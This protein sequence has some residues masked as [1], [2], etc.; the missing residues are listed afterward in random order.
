[1]REL[2]ITRKKDKKIPKSYGPKDAMEK[3]APKKSRTLEERNAGIKSFL[4]K[5]YNK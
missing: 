3:R 1:M 5:R 4:E 2:K